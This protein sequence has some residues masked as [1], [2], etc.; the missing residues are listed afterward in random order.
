M[1]TEQMIGVLAD[2]PALGEMLTRPVRQDIAMA[3][4]HGVQIEQVPGKG[5][6]PTRQQ[7]HQKV[8]LP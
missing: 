8:H 5:S 1:A 4:A 6:S 2:D 3:A 7:Q